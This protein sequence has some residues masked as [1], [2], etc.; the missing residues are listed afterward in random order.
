MDED[1]GLFKVNIHYFRLSVYILHFSFSVFKACR[2]VLCFSVISY[3]V[4]IVFTCCVR[5]AECDEMME[6]FTCT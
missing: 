6:L 2:A 3:H 1:G 4:I 5:I